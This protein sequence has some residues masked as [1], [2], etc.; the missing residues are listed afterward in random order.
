MGAWDGS[1]CC[2]LVGLYLLDKMKTLKLQAVLYTDDGLGVRNA[3]PRQLEK[4]KKKSV[5]YSNR[6]A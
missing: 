6:R 4:I 3:T 2:E 1:E 5:Q